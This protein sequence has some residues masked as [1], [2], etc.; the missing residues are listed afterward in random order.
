LNSTLRSFDIAHLGHLEILTPKPEESLHF[1]VNVMGMTE[2]GREQDS[3]YLRGWDD[4]EFHTIK[5]TASTVAGLGHFAFRAS[6]P[7]ALQRRV[8]IIEKAGYGKG[9][10]DGDLGHGPAYQ[11]TTSDNHNVEIYWETNW[12]KA[13]PELKP[14]LKNQAMRFPARGAN[15]RRLDHM[16][17][18]AAD[19]KALRIWFEDVLG[20]RVTE[21]IVLDSGEEAGVWVTSNNKTYD[22]AFTA[23]HYGAVGRFHHVT[24]AIDSRE[25]ILRAADVF[26]ENGVHIET[27]PHKHAIQQT[28]FLYVY[29]PGGNRVEVANAGA[30]LMLAP[31]WQP[32]V[33]TEAERKKGQAW[34]LKTIETFHTH[35]TPPI[36]QYVGPR[37]K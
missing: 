33:W 34:G 2:S 8:G 28:F 24:F 30:R 12:Y 4:Y 6:S 7:E 22:V 37:K 25:E 3:V 15:V 11:F 21:K 19:V 14:A 17:L 32:I 29:E 20:L 35:G 13:P 5:L 31:D 9:W 27:G 10:S 1:F 18:L 16:N 23:D 26:L 36:D